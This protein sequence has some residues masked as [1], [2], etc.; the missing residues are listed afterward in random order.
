MSVRKIAMFQPYIADGAVD[1]VCEVLKSRWV[2]QGG[3]VD[4]LE[5]DVSKALKIPYAVAVNASS[6]AIR[7]ALTICGVRPG[8]EVITTPMTCTL[9]NHPILEQFARIVFADVQYETGNI[10]PVDVERRITPQTR[11]IMC[12]HWGGQPADLHE[13]NEIANR[14]G[15][16]VIEDASEAFGATYRGAPIGAVSR[17]AAFSFQ[18]IQIIS[19]GE[20]GLLAVRDEGAF[21]QART[22]RWYG[23]DRDNRKANALGYYDFD[24][25]SVGF[26]YHLTNIAAAIGVENLKTLDAQRAHRRGVVAK[27]R[28]SFATAPGVTLLT[29]RPDR[30]S[31]NH[32]FTMHVERREDFCRK[33]KEAG[34]ETSIVHYRNDAYN[35]FGGLRSDLI[36]LERF[37]RS[38][39]GLPTHMHL[40]PDDVEHV[41]AT[42]RAGW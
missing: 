38:Y 31:S 2:G 17:F 12:T 32:F 7:L 6:A 42:V 14:H 9:T 26:G 11:A 34:I 23:I 4:E 36:G 29:E 18:A 25:T 20:G 10:D 35:V 22:L 21:R 40:G 8:D 33:M 28:S 3:L 16:S 24:I 37:S 30:E 13:L 5:K 19:A 41:V 15:L 27:Y 39:I 1:R